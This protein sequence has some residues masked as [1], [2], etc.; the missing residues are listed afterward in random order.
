MQG[1]ISHFRGSFRRKKG[2]HLI[3][4]VPGVDKLEK[5][6]PLLGKS[7]VWTAPG[8]QK[9]AIKGKVSS[10]HGNK[11]ALRVI[12]ERGLPGQSLGQEV[13]IE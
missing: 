9:T 4:V 3:V 8:K 12:F 6:K 2:N 1:I 10:T 7:A 13:K 5:A 11:G